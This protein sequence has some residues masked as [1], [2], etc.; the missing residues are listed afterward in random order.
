[1]ERAR[2]VTSSAEIVFAGEKIK[3]LEIV[4]EWRMTLLCKARWWAKEIF[5]HPLNPSSPPPN[6]KWTEGQ[7][8]WL[9]LVEYRYVH[10]GAVP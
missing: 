8:R 1:V 4:S 6:E 7:G 10:G 9:L 3:S 2:D 5:A